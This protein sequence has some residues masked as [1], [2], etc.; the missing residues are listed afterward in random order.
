RR[1]HT[2]SKRDWSSDVCSSD[3]VSSGSVK[4]GNRPFSQLKRPPSTTTPP[5]VVPCPPIHFVAEC[6][7]IS[8]PQLIGLVLC[9]EANVLS[10]IKG[11]PFSCAISATASISKTLRLGLV[12]VSPKIAFVLSLIALRKFSGSVPSTN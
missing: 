5:I 7:T 10:I 4:D 9:G 1:R 11:I 2:R 6:T 3:L 12:I 8:A